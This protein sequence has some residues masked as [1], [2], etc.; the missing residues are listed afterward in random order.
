MQPIYL[1]EESQNPMLQQRDHHIYKEKLQQKD[2]TFALLG[3]NGIM[4][5]D[6]NPLPVLAITPSTPTNALLDTA[7]ATESC[8]LPPQLKI[9]QLT[10]TTAMKIA[11]NKRM[12]KKYSCNALKVATILYHNEQQKED[13]MLAKE[14]EKKIIVQFSG[15][16]PCAQSIT[17]Y[18]NEYHLVGTL[19]LKA[20]NPGD[21]PTHAFKS[22]C[23]GL[24]RYIS[25]CQ[26]NKKC[27]KLGKQKLVVLVNTAV[28]WQVADKQKSSKLLSRIVK[29]KK[30][31]LDLVKVSTQE[32]RHIQWTKAK[33]LMMW[34][35]TWE[36]TLLELGFAEKLD[37]DG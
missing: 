32:I 9:F 22:L 24:E 12:M 37:V 7:S 3:N 28:N 6:P 25:I 31:D 18:V 33:Y 26:T 8:S 2:T 19:P 1:N 14:V 21:I 15:K 36:V 20:G 13:G 29:Y 17:W 27:A 23:V 30:I 35:N 16:G 10:I 34:F 4:F 5:I 11:K